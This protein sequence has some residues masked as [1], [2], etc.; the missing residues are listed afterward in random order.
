MRRLPYCSPFSLASIPKRIRL[1]HDSPEISITEIRNPRRNIM[2]I[3]VAAFALAIAFPAAAQTAPA[4]SS[5]PDQHHPDHHGQQQGHDQ[6]GQH[7]PGQ[8]EGHGDGCCADRANNGRMDCC[9]QG[10]RPAGQQGQPNG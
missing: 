10:D 4:Q 2:K 3:I 7:H 5:T 8:H 9:E 1:R 6:H